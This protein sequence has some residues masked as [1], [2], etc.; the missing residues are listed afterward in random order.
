ML[1]P[2][3]S[4]VLSAALLCSAAAS[5]LAAA[6]PPPPRYAVLPAFAGKDYNTECGTPAAA[7]GKALCDPNTAEGQYFSGRHNG[8]C[9]EPPVGQGA[10]V[11]AQRGMC[12]GFEDNYLQRTAAHR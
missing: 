8:H 5:G 7:K 9:D 4:A 10:V 6:S 1:T 3:L 12:K 2:K 11:I